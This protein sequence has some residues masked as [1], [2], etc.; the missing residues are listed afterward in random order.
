MAAQSQ[1]V[2][3]LFSQLDRLDIK[4]DVLYRRWTD[5]VT[6]QEVQQAIVPSSERRTVLKYHHDCRTACNLSIHKFLARVLSL[7][8]LVDFHCWS[9]VALPLCQLYFFLKGSRNRPPSLLAWVGA[10]SRN[11][12]C[13]SVHLFVD[14]TAKN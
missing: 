9:E 1:T 10:F 13:M 12:Q 7:I 2:K 6:G 14:V 11:Q 3:S 8:S 5:L 4:D